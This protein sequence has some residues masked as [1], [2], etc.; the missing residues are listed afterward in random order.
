[1]AEV[2]HGDIEDGGGRVSEH[3]KGR[4]RFRAPRSP[5]EAQGFRV[6]RCSKMFQVV[7]LELFRGR[8]EKRVWAVLQHVSAVA[9]PKKHRGVVWHCGLDFQGDDTARDET[10]GEAIY[11]LAKFKSLS[12]C[13]TFVVIGGFAN[14]TRTFPNAG[15]MHGKR[16]R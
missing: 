7:F 8:E 4:L 11:A 15:N 5:G 9:F 10:S 16:C 14:N 6:P 3:V 1:M 2:T 12:I 13:I